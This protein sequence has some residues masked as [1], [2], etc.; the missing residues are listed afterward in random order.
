MKYV[1]NMHMASSDS[2][3]YFEEFNNANEAIE[4]FKNETNNLVDELE[5]QGTPVD[6]YWYSTEDICDDEIQLVYMILDT[7]HNAFVIDFHME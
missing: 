2:V 6:D 3:F 4:A 7:T 1:L 5:K